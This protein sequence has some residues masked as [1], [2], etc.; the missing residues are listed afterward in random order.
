M[1]RK[2]DAMIQVS[3]LEFQQ[4]LSEYLDLAQR[5]PIEITRLGRSALVLTSAAHYE[6]LVAAA[7]RTHRTAEAASVVIAAVEAAEMDPEHEHLNE[8]T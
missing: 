1:Q 7:K 2:E 6:W 5:E 4:K 3:F 8:L